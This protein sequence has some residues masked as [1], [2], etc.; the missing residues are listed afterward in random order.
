MQ[1]EG[2]NVILTPLTDESIYNGR[3]PQTV[4]IW[5]TQAAQFTVSSTN[6]ERDQVTGMF[7]SSQ[8]AFAFELNRC[9]DNVKAT[10]ITPVSINAGL[11]IPNINIKNQN[12]TFTVQ[13]ALTHNITVPEGYY[14]R[15]GFLLEL[16]TLMTTAVGGG[17]TFTYNYNQNLQRA[18]ITISAGQFRFDSCDMIT[19]GQYLADFRHYDT[20]AATKYL[21]GLKM[22]YTPSIYVV[23]SRLTT[24]SHEMPKIGQTGMHY[25]ASFPVTEG[26]ETRFNAGGASGMTATQL[27]LDPRQP[28]SSLG[29]T[30][31]DSFGQE[32]KNYC[33]LVSTDFFELVVQISI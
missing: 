11:S 27:T 31:V 18:G 13:P 22:L 5:P 32:M 29:V 7:K 28:L 14:T 23:A 3:Q 8:S 19:A 25:F 10:R 20:Y 21:Y 26:F 6:R 1:I 2:S 9:F 4:K 33:P 15:D 30:L 12:V 16:T 17:I 24:T